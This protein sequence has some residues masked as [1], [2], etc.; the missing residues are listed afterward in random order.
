[1]TRL[2]GR[3]LGGPAGA[4]SPPSPGDEP[5]PLRRPG[6]RGEARMP[7]R[8]VHPPRE[9]LPGRPGNYDH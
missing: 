3:A 1:M 2:P 4:G 5:G 9:R 8:K 6:Q 7:Q